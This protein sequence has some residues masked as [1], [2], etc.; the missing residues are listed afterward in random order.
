MT[1]DLCALGC[2]WLSPHQNYPCDS[3]KKG[4]KSNVQHQHPR[5]SPPNVH[6]K[7]HEVFANLFIIFFSNLIRQQDQPQN[8]SEIFQ[9]LAPKYQG[10]KGEGW[11]GSWSPEDMAKEITSFLQPSCSPCKLKGSDQGS[12]QLPKSVIATL[13]KSH[14]L[15]R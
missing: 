14:Y 12:F 9:V 5:R 8:A 6:W 1:T 10:Y 2:K 15:V 13:I 4:E 3:G 11:L 7:T